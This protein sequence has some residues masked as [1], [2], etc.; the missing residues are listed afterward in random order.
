M[1]VFVRCE[2]WC[3]VCVV[4]MFVEETIYSQ[5]SMREEKGINSL[6]LQVQVADCG[7]TL[8]PR[9][10]HIPSSLCSLPQQQAPRHLRPLGQQLQSLFHREGKAFNQK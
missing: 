2:V 5:Y 10:G 9:P 3:G 6:L 4:F 7:W 8:C 1:V